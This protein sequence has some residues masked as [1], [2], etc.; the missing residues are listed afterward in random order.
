MLFEEKEEVK[1]PFIRKPHKQNFFE[2]EDETKVLLISRKP[3]I[4]N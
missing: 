4:F 3:S 2:N 1:R